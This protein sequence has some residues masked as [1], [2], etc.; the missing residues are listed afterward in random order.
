M[1]ANQKSYENGLSDLKLTCDAYIEELRR[2][3]PCVPLSAFC[4]LSDD[5]N[6]DESC[7]N[8][9]G[10]TVYKQFIDTKAD[11]SGVSIKKYKTVSIGDIAYVPTTNRNGDKIACGISDEVCIVSSTYEVLKVDKTQCDPHYLFMWFCRNEIDRYARFNS[12]GSAREVIAFEDLGAYRIPLPAIHVQQAIV[13]IYKCY[14]QRKAINE[15]LKTQIR[16]LCPILIRGS[17][18]EAQ[19]E[20]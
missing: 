13:N 6:E 17:I 11:M 1:V 19:K 3:M 10:L 9:K 12:W 7:N 8:V 5:R 15:R 2:K 18:E 20:A 16:C 4:R 14:L